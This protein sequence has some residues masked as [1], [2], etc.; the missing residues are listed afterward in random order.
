MTYGRPMNPLSVSIDVDAD[1]QT[2]WSLVSD[3]P[4]MGEWSPECTDVVWQGRAQGAEVGARFTGKNR[5]GLRRW[6]TQGTIVAAEPGRELAWDVSFFGMSVARWS[7][8]IDARPGGCRVTESCDDR[9]NKLLLTFSSLTTGVKD[10]EA[11]N[12]A[13]MR[14]TLERLKAAAESSSP[15]TAS[16]A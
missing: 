3:L 7:Y 6:S 16:G 10:R 5:N 13:G 11:H 14:T 1:P 8:A 9:R 4:R 2:V 15:T 12:V